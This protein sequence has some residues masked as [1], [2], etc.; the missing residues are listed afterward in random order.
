MPPTGFYGPFNYATKNWYLR[1]FNF[2]DI[3]EKYE[4]Y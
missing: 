1:V 3:E 2:L 4:L